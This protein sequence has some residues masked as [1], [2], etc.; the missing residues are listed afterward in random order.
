[1]GAVSQVVHAA[2]S[3]GFGASP[4]VF[5]RPARAGVVHFRQHRKT[6]ADAFL[7]HTLACSNSRTTVLYGFHRLRVLVVFGVFIVLVFFV[8]WLVVMTSTTLP[9]RGFLPRRRA[10]EAQ[11]TRAQGTLM[12]F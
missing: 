3:T 10:L 4:D 7:Y 6:H 12:R 11:I 1:M 8:H 9:V 5:H 2:C